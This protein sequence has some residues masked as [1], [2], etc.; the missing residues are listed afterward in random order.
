MNHVWWFYTMLCPRRNNGIG[1][2][3][4]SKSGPYAGNTV[5]GNFPPCRRLQ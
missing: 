3:L 1:W 2:T 5:R 4:V